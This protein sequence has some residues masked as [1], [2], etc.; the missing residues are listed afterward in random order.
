MALHDIDYGDDFN[1]SF[2]FRHRARWIGQQCLQWDAQNF[3]RSFQQGKPGI[4]LPMAAFQVLNP[5]A[6]LTHEPSE[7]GLGEPSLLTPVGDTASDA[8]S[9]QRVSFN[10][11]RTSRA[12]RPFYRDYVPHVRSTEGDSRDE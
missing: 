3:R 12:S 2:P 1:G 9:V 4:S 10:E 6:R 11:A 7:V 8:A 5:S